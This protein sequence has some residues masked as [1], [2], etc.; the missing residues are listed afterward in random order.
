MQLSKAIARST[1]IYWSQF[2]SSLFTKDEFKLEQVQ[3]QAARMSRGTGSQRDGRRLEV[4]CLTNQAKQR[5]RGAKAAL[6]KKNGGW[7]KYGLVRTRTN[8]C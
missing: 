8:R 1:W 7:K 2:W 4:P 5:L 3:R 6:A